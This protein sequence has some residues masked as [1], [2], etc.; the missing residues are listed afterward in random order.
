MCLKTEALGLQRDGAASGER[1]K[2]G[3][4]VAIGGLEDLGVC[5]GKQ[6]LVGGVLPDDQAFDEGEKSLPL[7]VLRRMGGELLRPRGR[8]VDELGKEHCPGGSER[9]LRPPLMQ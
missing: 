6:L 1:V 4:W 8:V 7:D 3:R 5:L 2:D 9:T